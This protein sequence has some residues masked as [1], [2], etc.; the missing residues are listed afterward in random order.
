MKPSL[1]T[2]Q[3]PHG[4][5]ATLQTCHK[6]Y[7]RFRLSSISLPLS[8]YRAPLQDFVSPVLFNLA[9]SRLST[10]W[11]QRPCQRPMPVMATESLLDPINYDGNHGS[12]LP[13]YSN[14]YRVCLELRRKWLRGLSESL[15]WV[16]C[17]LNFPPSCSSL[18]CT[19]IFIYR[20]R[21]VR[22]THAAPW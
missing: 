3:R 22:D 16:S 1:L 5:D 18:L 14:L 8:G 9:S 6:I 19:H 17:R 12:T 15:P 13:D 11:D 10:V 4:R 21:K 20:S 7:R 2:P